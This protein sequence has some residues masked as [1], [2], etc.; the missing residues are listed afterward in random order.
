MRL[1]RVP[2]PSI[3]N[4]CSCHCRLLRKGEGR[5]ALQSRSFQSRR[6]HQDPEWCKGVCNRGQIDYLDVPVQHAVCVHVV[7]PLQNI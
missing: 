2:D 7:Q 3:C 5:R 6:A 4:I 1:Q